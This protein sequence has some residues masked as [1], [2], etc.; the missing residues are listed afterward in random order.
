MIQYIDGPFP[1]SDLTSY[2]VPGWYFWCGLVDCVGPYRTEEEAKAHQALYYEMNACLACQ[3]SPA[4]WK[5]C[6][7][8]AAGLAR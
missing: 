6:A 5:P 1:D 7:K 4:G 3:P 8:H 2:S